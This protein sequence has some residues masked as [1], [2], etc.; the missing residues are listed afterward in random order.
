MHDPISGL[1]ARNS[2]VNLATSALPGAP[3]V[4]DQP[5]R[6]RSAFVRPLRR[7]RSR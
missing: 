4:P 3:V 7:L 1:F 2:S 5:V 6:R